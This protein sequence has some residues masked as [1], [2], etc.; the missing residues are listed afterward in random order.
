MI[1]RCQNG[2]LLNSDHV[3]EWDKQTV[4]DGGEDNEERTHCH[5]KRLS[6]IQLSRFLKAHKRNARSRLDEIDASLSE[7]TS[8]CCVIYVKGFSEARR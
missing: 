4:G 2:R 6:S 7:D 5:R 3:V 1:I 8:P